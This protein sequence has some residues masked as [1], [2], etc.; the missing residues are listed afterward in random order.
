MAVKVKP[1]MYCERCQKPVAAQKQTH[2]ARSVLLGPVTYG[3]GVK[4]GEWH[5]PDCGGPV[6]SEWRADRRKAKNE[7][8]AAKVQA[9]FADQGPQAFG[10]RIKALPG[11]LGTRDRLQALRTY[12]E[13]T[14]SGL[15]AAKS[16]LKNLPV[17]IDG[18]HR[19]YADRVVNAIQE[20]GGEA[21][22]VDPAET[23]AKAASGRATASGEGDISDQIRQLGALRDEG[24]LTEQE[25]EAKKAELLSRL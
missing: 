8:G 6:V 23:T 7:R 10:V 17:T 21:E 16:A 15:E 14:G 5:C 22:V 1:G 25:F 24:L 18:L 3:A 12:R 20:L 19:S 4:V 2:K 13:A 9:E 11:N